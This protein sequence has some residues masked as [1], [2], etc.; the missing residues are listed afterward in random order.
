MQRAGYIT[1]AQAAAAQRAPLGVQRTAY[2]AKRRESYFFDYVRTE[3]IK[4]YGA[5]RVR[6]GG[7]K[8]YTTI[9]LKL[10]QV[11]RK[12]IANRLPNPGDPSAAMVS[13][14]PK[15]GYIKAMASSGRLRRLEVQPRRAGPPPA[16]LDVQGHGA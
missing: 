10:Q 8:V 9:D 6:Q 5:A 16:G 14:D 4:K 15:T 11:A 1:P 13:M 12:A 3:L 2:Y 7:L